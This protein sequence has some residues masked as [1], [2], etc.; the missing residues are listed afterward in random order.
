MAVVSL[1]FREFD[2]FQFGNVFCGSKGPFRWRVEPRIPKEKEERDK[3]VLH[4]WY[5]WDGLC[6][7]K[8]SPAG[9]G[10]FPLTEAGLEEAKAWLGE[11]FQDGPVDPPA[12]PGEDL[13]PF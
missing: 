3:S 4:L 11:R 7:E 5:W 6:F 9:E 2:Y 12:A 13:P 1:D 10:E 8:C